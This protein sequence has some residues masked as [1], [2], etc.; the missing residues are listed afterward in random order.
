MLASEPTIR[1]FCPCMDP[2]F[3][4]QDQTVPRAPLAISCRPCSII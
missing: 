3:T 1:I 4:A 2:A